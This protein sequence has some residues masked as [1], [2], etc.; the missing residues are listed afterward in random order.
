MSNLNKTI[1]LM[2]AFLV[3][4]CAGTTVDE[5]TIRRPA[6]DQSEGKAKA[7]GANQH[8]VP[9]AEIS[10]KTKYTHEFVEILGSKMA[11]IDV[12]TG[13]PILFLHGQ[14]TSSYLW[15]NVMPHLEGQGR[16]IAPDNIGF[17]KSDQPELDYTFGDHYRYFEAFVAQLDL[18]NVTLV[19]HD[20]GSGLGLNYARLHPENVKG[21]VT[22]ESIVA[23]LIPAASYEALPTDIGNFFRT[24]RDPVKG[25]KMLIDENYFVENVLPGFISRPLDKEA[26]DVY[27]APFL[28]KSS[29]KQVNQW[30][31]EMP[32][33][34]IP[35]ET[36]E[37]VSA[38]NQWL[39][40]TNTPWLFLY[41]SP[42]ALNPPETAQYWSARAKNIETS[43]IGVGIH[44]VQ[45]DQPFAIGSTISDWYR[46][47]SKKL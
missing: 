22:M 21:I 7:E 19:V 4:A 13:D 11:Y 29:R 23:P 9:P 28:T 41:A 12:G 16:L 20:W 37:I 46:R 3:A 45:E 26:H 39:E 25:P 32:I 15:R 35:A 18:K 42:G 40:T 10:S 31:N 17:G 36:T 44:Y 2:S 6:T 30:P 47:L 5:E 1:I 27:R 43:F 33:G 14:P 34:G 24:V 8:K 38:Y